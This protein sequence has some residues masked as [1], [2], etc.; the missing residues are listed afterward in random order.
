MIVCIVLVCALLGLTSVS[1]P[2]AVHADEVPPVMEGIETGKIGSGNERGGGGSQAMSYGGTGFNTY[3][4]LMYP[5]GYSCIMNGEAGITFAYQNVNLPNGSLIYGIDFSGSDN[6]ETLE[7]ALEFAESSYIGDGNVLAKLTSG[8]EFHGGVYV[9]SV[10]F[11]PPILVDNPSNNYVLALTMP[12]RGNTSYVSF[13][14]ATIYYDP[15]S[16]FAQALPLVSK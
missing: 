11:D 1:A 5:Y 10:L 6:S 3:N 9:R 14:Q 2:K 7:M 8:I 13:C 12:G 4:A 15:P 16:I